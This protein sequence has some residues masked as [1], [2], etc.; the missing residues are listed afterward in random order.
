MVRF[1]IRDDMVWSGLEF[2][3]RFEMLWFRLGLAGGR[4][5]VR[6]TFEF[7]VACFDTGLIGRIR[8]ACLLGVA[9]L[10]LLTC[11][12]VWFIDCKLRACFVAH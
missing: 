4:G 9:S 6:V 11:S 12:L 10:L 1:E 2:G 5:E 8:V 3:L 7:E